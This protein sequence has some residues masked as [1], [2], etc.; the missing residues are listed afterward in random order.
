MKGGF[1]EFAAN[2]SL[3]DYLHN[4]KHGNLHFTSIL[5]WATEIAQGVHYLHYEAPD[6][7]IHRD[8]KSKN[9]VLGKD[10]ICKLCDFGTSKNLTHSQTAP[11]WGGTAAWMR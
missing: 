3:F 4:Q 10:N 7:I 6:V 9:V 2:G 8:L 11:T 1:A 5:D